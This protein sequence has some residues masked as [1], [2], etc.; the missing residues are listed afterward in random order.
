MDILTEILSS[1]NTQANPQFNLGTY[2]TTLMDNDANKIIGALLPYNKVN[3][4]EYPEITKMEDA[5]II[6][7]Q[8]IIHL[9][10][11]S[12]SFGMSTL[13]SSEAI[14]MAC[15]ALKNG[16]VGTEKPNM[17]VSDCAHSSWISATRLLDI[18]LRTISLET[19][20][21]EKAILDVIDRNTIGI[22]LTLGT[23]STGAFEP[24]QDIDNILSAYEIKNE[25]HIPIH[26]DAASGGFIAPFQFPDL[27]W[28]FRLNHVCS[29]NISGHKYGMV[30]PSIGWVFW[31]KKDIYTQKIKM[32]IDYL[33]NEFTHFGVNFSAPSAFIA[34]QYYTFI[35][36]GY[37][38]YVKKV[39]DLFRLKKLIENELKQIPS[40]IVLSNDNPVRLP[41]VCWAYHE[42]YMFEIITKKFEELGWI[43]PCCN[44]SRND[45]SRCCRIVIRH[46]FREEDAMRLAGDIATVHR[47]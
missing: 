44:I 14:L 32:K 38:G 5:C 21:L 24:I 19:I 18:E 26:V 40:L 37:S 31:K 45:S 47:L 30:Y 43:V 11:D 34:A 22:G 41:V 39:K 33:K 10:N 1:L 3:R 15:Y 42:D 12:D 8:K 46:N 13:G 25:H 4:N 23:T 7:L 28:D 6:F 20:P 2:T 36:Y 27:K 29:I 35:K 16:Y 17:I 9:S